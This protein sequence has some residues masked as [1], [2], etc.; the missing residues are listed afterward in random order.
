M[1]PD[2][3]RRGVTEVDRFGTQ[4]AEPIHESIEIHSAKV[5]VQRRDQLPLSGVAVE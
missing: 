5:T 1:E 3:G 2:D 4:S